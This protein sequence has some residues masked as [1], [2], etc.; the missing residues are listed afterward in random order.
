MYEQFL[1]RITAEP[2]SAIY[3]RDDDYDPSSVQVGRTITFNY[4]E[5]DYM[6]GAGGLYISLLEFDQRDAHT[7]HS[8]EIPKYFKRTLYCEEHDIS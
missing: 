1:E 4:D 3:D 7:C 6:M 5:R 2:L 8:G